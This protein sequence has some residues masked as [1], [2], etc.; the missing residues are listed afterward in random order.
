MLNNTMLTG[1]SMSDQ[2]SRIYAL[3]LFNEFPINL[4]LCCFSFIFIG[5][6]ILIGYKHILFRAFLATRALSDMVARWFYAWMNA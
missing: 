1:I 2:I 5:Y 6:W 3:H 4:L